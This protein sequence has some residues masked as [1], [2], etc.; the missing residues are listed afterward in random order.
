MRIESERGVMSKVMRE[1]KINRRDFLKIATISG[2]ALLLPKN[3]HSYFDFAAQL[4][5]FPQSEFIGRNCLSGIMNFRVKPEADAEINKSVY[6]DFLFPIYR[7]VVGEAPAGTYNATWFETPYGYV[8][9]PGVQLVKNEPNVP[10][11]ALPDSSIGKG[12]WGVVTV[13]Y[14]NLIFGKDPVSPWYISIKDHNPKLYYDQIF[15]IDEIKTASD[16]TI[17]YR[18]NELYGTYGDIVYADA[19]AIRKITDEEVAPIHPEVENKRIYVNLTYQ[20]LTC[21]END[22]EV[23]FCR[24]S[25][26]AMYT[27][28]G[29]LTDRYATP[30][31]NHHPWRKSISLHMSGSLTGSGWDTPGVPWNVI[32]ATGGA[33]IHGVF[34]HNAFGT[35]RSHGCVNAKPD[36]A[37]WICRWVKPEVGLDPGDITVSGD[38][39]TLIEVKN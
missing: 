38:V 29:V 2:G 5:T 31:G 28:E 17:L 26:G 13:P 25:S 32:F 22:V 34:W 7:E 20:T 36:D 21:Y 24:I 12:F 16:G 35:P 8:Y 14:V 19:R 1:N 27:N 15:W 9:S 3:V 37:K 11:T 23:Y 30:T 39:G 33:S 4:D 10:E 18:A 6:E